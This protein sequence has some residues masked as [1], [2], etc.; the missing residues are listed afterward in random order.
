LWSLLLSFLEFHHPFV[1]PTTAEFLLQHGEGEGQ[2]CRRQQCHVKE[3]RATRWTRSSITSGDVQKLCALGTL[4]EATSVE[5][6]VDE[7]IP[8]PEAGYWLMFRDF[9]FHGLSVLAHRFLRGLLFVY[10]VQL[11]HLTPNSILHIACFI[12]LCECFLGIDPH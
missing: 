5:M 1:A 8:R 6:L 10:G 3:G 2:A 7:V 11:H 4:A 12:T 9:I